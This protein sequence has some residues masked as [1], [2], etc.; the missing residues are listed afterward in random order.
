MQIFSDVLELYLIVT[1]TRKGGAYTI[2]LTNKDLG[3][4]WYIKR[5]KCKKTLLII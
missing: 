3:D 1:L 5:T 2:T 4:D